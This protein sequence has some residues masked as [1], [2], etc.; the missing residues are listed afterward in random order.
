M[1]VVST[2]D[3][4]SAYRIFSVMNDRRLDLSHADILK[5]EIIGAIDGEEQQETYGRRW[6]AV[7]DNLGREAFEE[8]FAHIRMIHVKQKMRGTILKEIRR[9]VEPATQ[10]TAFVEEQLEPYADAL[11]TIKSAGY[12]STQGAETINMYL[13]WLNRVDNVDWI[14]PAIL[15]LAQHESDSRWLGRFFQQLERL[16]AGLLVMRAGI[17]DRLERY[18]KLLSALQNG[19]DVLAPPSDLYLTDEERA[20]IV[21]GLDGDLYEMT[22]VRAYVLLRLDHAL[23]GGGAVYDY[24]IITI[25]HVLPQTPPN[26]SKWFEWFPDE[27]ERTGWV[28][29]IGNLVLLSRKKNGEAQNFEFDTKKEKYFKSDKG[30]SPFVLTTQVLVETEWT[31]VRLKARQEALVAKLKEVW[32]L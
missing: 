25:E 22:K 27:K 5:A 23:S 26:G 19:Q 4:E 10:P 8:L 18:S 13:G 2:P 21:K 20:K 16:A 11:K 3:M 32:S 24:P 29:R 14:P 12:Q 31:P 30:I 1:V 15:A 28:H 17:N 6:E 9:F 7:E